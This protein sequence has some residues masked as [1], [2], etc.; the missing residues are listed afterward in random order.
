MSSDRLICKASNAMIFR[1]R[2]AIDG[3]DKKQGGG[4]AA[5]YEKKSLNNAGNTSINE[6]ESFNKHYNKELKVSEGNVDF[7]N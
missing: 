4:A 1:F 6:N 3:L 2:S 7:L 5:N